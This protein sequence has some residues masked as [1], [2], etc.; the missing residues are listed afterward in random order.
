[1]KSFNLLANLSI[2]A[3]ILLMLIFPVGGLLFFSINT[4]L[5]KTEMVDNMNTIKPLAALAVK[6]SALVHET[7]KERGL[8]AGFLGSKGVKFVVELPA[9]RANTDKALSALKTFLQDFESAPYGSGFKGQLEG[10]Q[11]MLNKLEGTRSAVSALKIRTGDAIGYYTGLNANF[12]NIIGT[13]TQYSANGDITRLIA[14]YTNFLEGKERAGIER[15]ILTNTFSQ[16]KFG[17]GMFKHFTSLV[18]QQDIYTQV[19]LSTATDEAIQVYKQKLNSPSVKSVE[20]MRNV[21]FAKSA[22]GN[23]GIDAGVWFNTI[24]NKINLLKETEDW[25]S[26]DLIG[27]VTTLSDRARLLQIIFIASASIAVILALLLAFIAGRNITASLGRT[28]EALKDIAEKDIAGGEVDLGVRLD[29][30]GKD[31][32]AQL[33]TAFNQFAGKIETMVTEQAKLVQ[34]EEENE[35]LNNSVVAILRSVSKLGKGDL[36]EHAPVNEDITGALADAINQMS[37]GIGGTLGQVSNASQQVRDAS[38]EAKNITEESKKSVSD[39]AQEMGE[40]RTTIQETAKRIKRL[41]ERSQ[42]IGSIVKLIDDISE[43]TNVLALNANMQAAQAGE[44]GRGFMVVADEVQRLAESSKEATDQI[45]KLVTGMQMETG[46]TIST[47]DKAIEEVV[48]GGRT[49]EQA[50]Q[51]MEKAGETVERLDALGGEL[52]KAVGAF[53]LPQSTLDDDQKSMRAVG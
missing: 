29:D 7:Q 8:T 46:E 39:T 23:F 21:A 19:F 34:T 35:M 16:D 12:L 24:T 30:A 47:M 50:A 43:R 44:A 4:V 42:E 38:V 5:V 51:Q 10:V 45:T 31:E 15:A 49:A 22:K 27:Q 9:Q 52:L 37:E 3:K 2:K 20:E 6:A 48:Q 18:A 11:L 14:S 28:L 13:T 17:K 41:G 1:M 32:T 36:T 53:K 25:L 26:K 40:I 33:A